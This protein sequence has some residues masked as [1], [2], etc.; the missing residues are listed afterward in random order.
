MLFRAKI[1]ATFAISAMLPVI[2]LAAPELVAA[3]ACAGNCRDAHNQCRIRTKNSPSCDAQLQ[4]C[5]Q[6]CLR[7]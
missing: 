1:A 2:V 5:L 7:K 6:G 3:N 4:A